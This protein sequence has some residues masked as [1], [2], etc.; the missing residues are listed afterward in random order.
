MAEMYS[1]QEPKPFR[2]RLLSGWYQT[3][4]DS[5]RRRVSA[6]ARRQGIPCPSDESNAFTR[7]ALAEAPGLLEKVRHVQRLLRYAH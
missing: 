2:R 1:R 6:A 5:L 7:I 3:L 4:N